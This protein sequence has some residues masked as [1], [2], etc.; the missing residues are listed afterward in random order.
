M[1]EPHV[2][3]TFENAVDNT[4]NIFFVINLDINFR[5]SIIKD[6]E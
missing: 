2:H 1:V 3:I 6:F 5:V 4:R